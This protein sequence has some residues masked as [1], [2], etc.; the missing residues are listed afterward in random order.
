MFHT[1]GENEDT[2]FELSLKVGVVH[3]MP[4]E[5]ILKHY[6][7]HSTYKS[8]EQYSVISSGRCACVLCGTCV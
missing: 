5:C 2:P 3:L 4:Y 1:S 7:A 6:N 8:S